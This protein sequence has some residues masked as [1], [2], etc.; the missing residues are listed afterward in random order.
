MWFHAAAV[1]GLV[2]AVGAAHRF[3]MSLLEARAA[4]LEERNRIAHEI[5]DSLAQGLAGIILQLDAVKRMTRGQ[6]VP[7][8]P[9]VER[10]SDLARHSLEEAR[11]S[12]WALRPALLEKADLPQALGLLA[13]QCAS[14]GGAHIELDVQGVPRP[15]AEAIEVNL[16]RIAQA[17]VTNALKH[18][19]PQTVFI[20]LRYD[21]A[22]VALR[23]RDDGSGFEGAEEGLPANLGFGIPNMLRRA[24][25]LGA[26]LAIRAA[27]GQGTEVSVVVRKPR[28]LLLHRLWG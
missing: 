10:A 16:F 24:K 12:V 27:P 28:S 25:L 18:A 4:V 8:D 1:I 14:E 19:A 15:L 22:K 13:E 5:H 23:V 20:E 26:R 17:A 7:S 3:R 2:L 9:Y 11:R 6:A 21:D